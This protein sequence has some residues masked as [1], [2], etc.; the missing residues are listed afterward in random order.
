MGSVPN[1]AMTEIGFGYEA[2]MNTVGV[3]RDIA[4]NTCYDPRVRALA[5]DITKDLT[6]HNYYAEAEAIGE[7]VQKNVRYVRD[8]AGVEQLHDPI[9]MIEK[10]YQGQASGDCDDMVLLIGTLLLSIGCVPFMRVVKYRPEGF[11]WN[12]IYVVVY[13]KTGARQ[14]KQRLVL[15]AIVKD[16]KIGYEIPHDSGEEIEF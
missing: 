13:E 2:N 8:I 6:S 4:R 12:H 9:Y 14:P 16:K 7:F 10:L 1:V 5:L 3:I 15:D 11:S